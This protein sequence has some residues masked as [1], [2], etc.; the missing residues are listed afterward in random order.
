MADG[1]AKAAPHLGM[2]HGDRAVFLGDGQ[3]R[4]KHCDVLAVRGNLSAVAFDDIGGT[5]CMTAH[6]HV[7]PRRPRP[8]F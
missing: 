1:K 5:W 2:A 3:C 4:G 8:D 6:L 7:I